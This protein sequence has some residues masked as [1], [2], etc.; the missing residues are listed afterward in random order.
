MRMTEAR[1]DLS[2]VTM[3]KA[4]GYPECE[5]LTAH[6]LALFG[7]RCDG[8][9]EVRR[10][11]ERSESSGERIVPRRLPKTVPYGDRPPVS[12]NIPLLLGGHPD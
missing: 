12:A 2:I 6:P 8:G 9:A 3:M 11:D 7:K 4:V 5:A 1:M 10:A